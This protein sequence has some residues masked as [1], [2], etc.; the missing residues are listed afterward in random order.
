MDKHREARER[1]EAME[2]A[3]VAAESK[4]PPR[5]PDSKAVALM[6]RRGA[7]RER[8]YLTH[9]S[10]D[11]ESDGL[12]WRAGVVESRADE[13]FEA[14][15]TGVSAEDFAARIAAREAP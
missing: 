1:I 11:V 6:L 9:V 2:K 14:G 15:E 7:E 8:R 4:G 5:D 3:L 13:L 10:N 12:L